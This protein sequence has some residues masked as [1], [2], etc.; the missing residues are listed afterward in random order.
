MKDFEMA[1]TFKTASGKQSGSIVI[2]STAEL[3]AIIA[4]SANLHQ[5]P[6]VEINVDTVSHN[7][8]KDNVLYLVMDWVYMPEE[9][10]FYQ[11]KVE[12]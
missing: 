4:T 5:D 10:R 12:E 1:V 2:D 9:R 8:T 6:I 3:D 11:V 7:Y